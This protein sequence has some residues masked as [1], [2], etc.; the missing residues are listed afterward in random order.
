M[1]SFLD[2]TDG[3]NRRLQPCD[4]SAWYINYFIFNV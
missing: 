2:R 3:T 1:Q 4:L